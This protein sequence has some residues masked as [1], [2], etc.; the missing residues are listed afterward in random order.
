MRDVAVSEPIIDDL[1]K[2]LG[3]TDIY[4]WLDLQAERLSVFGAD[5]TSQGVRL[6]Q[7]LFA[8]RSV[9]GVEQQTNL[10]Q[11]ACILPVVGGFKIQYRQ[12]LPRARRRFA[13]AHELG[14]TYFFQ[15][16]GSTQTVSRLQGAEE[17]T[18]EALCDFF[19]GAL[20]L[21]RQ[22]F[23]NKMQT[24][25]GDGNQREIPPLHLIPML[26]QEFAVAPQAVARRMVFDIFASHRVV[27][28]VRRNVGELTGPWHTVWY[29]AS[30]DL[31]RRTPTGWRIALDSHGRTF[32]PELIPDTPNGETKFAMID[33]RLHSA[34]NPQS[35]D[36]SRKPISK[37]IP[38]PPQ[39]ALVARCFAD[40]DL[41]SSQAEFAFVA[42]QSNEQ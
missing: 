38:L 35:P 6:T 29:A 14:H 28:C 17:P 2:R 40:S 32:P 1:Q 19:A 11:E 12:G 21:P 36:E 37:R 16:P 13:I 39:S 33:G 7:Q 23:L 26:A 5:Q 3:C 34:A 25:G 20:L 22:R 4:G 30:I 18:I 31:H 42:I 41:F 27:F 8:A 24:F 9:I 15:E 10:N